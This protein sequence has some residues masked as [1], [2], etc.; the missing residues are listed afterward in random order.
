MDE[1]MELVRRLTQ[2]YTA[3]ESTSVPEETALQLAEAVIFILGRQGWEQE[4]LFSTKEVRLEAVYEEGKGQILAEVR[5]AQSLYSGIMENFTSCGNLA[6]ED[7]MQKGMP[8][9][10]L[11]Y[12]AEFAPQDH[13]LTLDYPILEHLEHLQGIDRIIAYLRCIR[14][15][16]DFL[17]LLPERDL[18][19]ILRQ[20]N[21]SFRTH[22]FNLP[23]IVLSKT[24][25][26]LLAGTGSLRKPFDRTEYEVMEERIRQLGQQN[27]GEVVMKAVEKLPGLKADHRDY[28]ALA[29]PGIAAEFV[30]GAENRC[31]ERMV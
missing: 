1:F 9:F 16:Q 6:L 4:A 26:C 5:Q 18:I 31:L 2:R 24:A 12:D 27:L 25:A 8:Q 7:T 10:F 23:Q 14:L 15:E 29:V 30:T 19:Q 3:G 22:I 13:L 17:H 20:W 11:R 21:P 28:L